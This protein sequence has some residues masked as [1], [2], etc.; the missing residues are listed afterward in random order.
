V[1]EYRSIVQ[2]A[3]G[4]MDAL[5]QSIAPLEQIVRDKNQWMGEEKGR[6]LSQHLDYT[7]AFVQGMKVN[8]RGII[9]GKSGRSALESV[10]D[11]SA[12][13]RVEYIAAVCQLYGEMGLTRS[14]SS[15][16]LHMRRFR[17]CEPLRLA[18]LDAE[19]IW[20]TNDDDN[21]NDI[22]GSSG[23]DGSSVLVGDRD[24]LANAFL[25]V[26][27]FEIG[28]REEEEWV[29]PED[30]L[31]HDEYDREGD[32]DILGDD[33]DHD[34]YDDDDDDNNN[35]EERDNMSV[36][37]PDLKKN[38]N[39][40][41]GKKKQDED[42]PH[43]FRS[44]FGELMRAN[45]HEHAGKVLSRIDDILSVDDEEG[46]Q[47]IMMDDDHLNDEEDES[48]VQQENKLVDHSG[49]DPMAAQMIRNTL[50]GRIGQIE[51]GDELA[52]SAQI[53][54]H[55]LKN[56]VTEGELS[57]YLDSLVLGV[58]N[59]A[60]MS[61][62][63][64]LEVISILHVDVD[65]DV[66]VDS[67]SCVSPYALLVCRKPYIQG[68]LIQ[69]CQERQEAPYY[70]TGP[71]DEVE[72]PLSAPDGYYG[73]H[74]PAPRE[75]NDVL[76]QLFHGY[77]YNIFGNSDIS[78]FDLEVKGA[79]K[80]VEKLKK[81]VEKLKDDIGMDTKDKQK[82]GLN[83]ELYSI[84]DEC[85][86]LTAGKYTYEVCMFGRS[87][88]KEGNNKGGTDLGKWAGASLDQSTGTRVWKWTGGQKCW[89]G[90]KRSATV[91]VTCGAETKMISADEPN[92]CEYEFK[93]ESHIGCDDRYRT[94][95][96][97]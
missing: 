76:T 54:L 47:D 42:K 27:G 1:E 72:I 11:L 12:D 36:P 65:V 58:T 5:H 63:D 70:C 15:S 71:D 4:E 69:R 97:F 55:A 83:G 25:A 66:D 92:V 60:N 61:E 96:D 33:E 3:V 93:M 45:F 52:Q 73:Y 19:L 51:Y 21:D 38:D 31:I 94:A 91:F 40:D 86:E 82:F 74:A 7:H 16:S 77:D 53:M 50:S 78:T 29:D 35:D 62:A 75:E 81:K 57:E 95:H 10:L 37:K 84:R 89:N 28:E 8:D 87:Y 43:E 39:N 18:G 2:D 88:Q 13:L 85:F 26:A 46:E 14:S 30:E 44:K 6:I 90:P 17:S 79:K 67:E 34:H 9:S 41:I 56:K 22:D 80:E 20:D 68:P 23:S 64:V 32:D 49:I 59:R 24:A 48:E